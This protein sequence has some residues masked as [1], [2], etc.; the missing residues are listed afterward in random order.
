MIVKGRVVEKITYCKLRVRHTVVDYCSGGHLFGL[1]VSVYCIMYLFEEE[2][3]EGPG[4]FPLSLF[5][6]TLMVYFHWSL[7]CETLLKLNVDSLGL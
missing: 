5:R 3:G 1:L 4:D 2:M 6:E 7:L